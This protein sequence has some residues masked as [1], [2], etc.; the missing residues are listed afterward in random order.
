ML[1][2]SWAWLPQPYLRFGYAC[3]RLFR[4]ERAWPATVSIDDCLVRSR[5]CVALSLQSL[6]ELGF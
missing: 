6:A 4:F 1:P 3:T 5:D 2:G